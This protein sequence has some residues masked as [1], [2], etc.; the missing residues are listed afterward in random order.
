MTIREYC[1]Y[2]VTGTDP[3]LKGF[4]LASELGVHI[5]DLVCL[6]ILKAKLD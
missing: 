6:N 4:V 5:D 1:N 2:H 3:L